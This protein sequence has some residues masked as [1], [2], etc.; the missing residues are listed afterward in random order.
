MIFL[1]N[2]D[3][4]EGLYKPFSIFEHTEVDVPNTIVVHYSV[5]S[6]YYQAVYIGKTWSE[7]LPDLVYIWKFTDNGFN[8]VV[9]NAKITD[10]E[11]PPETEL[12]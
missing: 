11:V 7:I 5:N 2:I 6:E 8:I 9:I 12:K 10:I 1:F 4:V 3:T